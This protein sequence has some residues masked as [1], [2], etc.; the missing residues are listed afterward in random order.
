M[1]AQAQES[2]QVNGRL[3][4]TLGTPLARA[5]VGVYIVGSQD[6]LKTITNNVGFYLIK[7][8]PQKKFVIMFSS[9]GYGTTRKALTMPEGE[10]VLKMDDYKLFPEYSSM[11][12]IVISTP[13][14]IVKE[15]TVE[16]KA[17]S[18]RLKPNA[19]VEDLLKKMPGIEVDKNGT[20]TAQGKR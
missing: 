11:Q 6:T 7:G 16:Y 19:M 20:I 8:I 2:Y 18:F 17:D 10:E 9:V 15:D 4:D 3:V 1:N 14:I 13:P 12:E 5:T